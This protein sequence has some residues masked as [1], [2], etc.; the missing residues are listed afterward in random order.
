VDAAA[1]P[2]GRWKFNVGAALSALI[3]VLWASPGVPAQ[4]VK[5]VEFTPDD[6]SLYSLDWDTLKESPK[7]FTLVNLTADRLHL[8]V[9]L[10][11]FVGPDQKGAPAN[12][13]RYLKIDPPEFD[14]SPQATIRFKITAPGGVP[15]ALPQS[16]NYTGFLTIVG[17]KDLLVTP[18]KQFKIGFP[19]IRA[20]PSPAVSRV[21]VR[22]WRLWPGPIS[23]AL[24]GGDT[25][26]VPLKQ[27]AASIPQETPRVFHLSRS[28]GGEAV[29]RWID[30]TGEGQN[31]SS[32]TIRME[33]VTH[34]GQYDGTLNFGPRA[35]SADG[36]VMLG[37][38]TGYVPTYGSDSPQ[39][40]VLAT[41]IVIWPVGVLAAAII[42]SQLTKY[43]LN[44]K[45]QVW[46][47]RKQEAEVGVL[48]R[49][50]SREFSRSVA[51][52]RLYTAYSI[53]ADLLSHRRAILERIRTVEINSWL[54]L[55]EG[56]A[57]GGDRPLSEE[58]KWLV[59][60]VRAWDQFPAVLRKLRDELVRAYPDDWAG[61]VLSI[62]G[63]A[64]GEQPDVVTEC[65]DAVVGGAIG[66][67][68]IDAVAARLTGQAAFLQVWGGAFRR[69]VY[70]RNLSGEIR[71]LDDQKPVG[72]RLGEA[73]REKLAGAE[74]KL[75]RVFSDLWLMKT[76]GSG[77]LQEAN[78]SLGE[79][80]VLLRQ[81]DGKAA[82]TAVPPGGVE[83]AVVAPPQAASAPLSAALVERLSARTREIDD[84]RL[85]RSANDV[86]RAGHYR[87]AIRRWDLVTTAVG[88]LVALI[89]G[90]QIYYFGANF[91]TL[92]DYANLFVWGLGAQAVF[93]VLT[94]GLGR[95]ITSLRTSAV[96]DVSAPR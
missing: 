70:C 51:E 36:G 10:S 75:E 79:V 50:E 80:E 84:W 14:L 1:W 59:T 8:R 17:A 40:I 24:I 93:E 66:V 57:A 32:I 62:P 21:Y 61:A 68:E 28:S 38:S 78:K 96:A 82:G 86:L 22:V 94:A 23:S 92:K 76:D 4:T 9:E 54:T 47:W 27:R 18:R 34:A 88:A 90:L 43:Y 83:S 19:K 89:G 77:S 11:D 30:D 60:R 2:A 95:L 69:T 49:Q 52:H 64:A 35:G 15:P 31:D 5:Q 29:A 87:E 42:I 71:T 33:G 45:R 56:Q 25:F 73:E 85:S 6:A 12:I 55:Q 26:Q 48:Y 67:G 58:L 37:G 91:G 72:E 81:L 39:I 46:D 74:K 3:L 41:D 7:V 44:V 63:T 53:E 65:N 20:V 13:S 16:G